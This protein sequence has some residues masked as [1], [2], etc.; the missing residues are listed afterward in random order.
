MLERETKDATIPDRRK[1]TDV[2]VKAAL[3]S[4]AANEIAAF[5]ARVEEILRRV[6][7]DWPDAVCNNEVPP[8]VAFLLFS[9]LEALQETAQE[10]GELAR[11][12][13]RYDEEAVRSFW[14]A[15]G[16]PPAQGSPAVDRR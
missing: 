1:L 4:L 2:Q 3:A 8:S 6:R 13:S 14:E 7:G 12:A 15:L 11:D 5:T 10:A 9:A 16:G